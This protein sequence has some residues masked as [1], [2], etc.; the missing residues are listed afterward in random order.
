MGRIRN[1]KGLPNEQDPARSESQARL[2]AQRVPGAG[3]AAEA[4]NAEPEDAAGAVGAEDVLHYRAKHP[5]GAPFDPALA[6]A[7]SEIAEN[8]RF[9][10]AAAFRLVETL[11]AEPAELGRTADLLELRI[12]RCQLGLFGFEPEKRIVKP[13]DEVTE[14]LRERLEAATVDGTISCASLWEIADALGLA[15][16]EVSAACECLRVKITPCQLGAF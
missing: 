2:P 11:G 8:D 16:M 9:T 1:I 7:L 14:E 3:H 4:K 13:A 10:C 5:R 6:R 12:T 15:R